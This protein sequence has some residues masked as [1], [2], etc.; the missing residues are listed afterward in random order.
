VR[1]APAPPAPAA[2]APPSNLENVGEAEAP[3]NPREFFDAL[4]QVGQAPPDELQAWLQAHPDLYSIQL[5]TQ[6]VP[7][8]VQALESAD[9]LPT[10]G[11]LEFLL[12]FFGL[13]HIDRRNLFLQP[14]LEKLRDLAFQ[15]HHVRFGPDMSFMLQA[16]GEPRRRPASSGGWPQVVPVLLILVCLSSL[17][18]CVG[19]TSNGSFVIDP[20]AVPRTLP[21]ERPPAS[22]D[23]PWRYVPPVP[24][25]PSSPSQKKP[26]P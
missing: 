20:D 3:F 2:D 12:D 10:P 25:P 26:N 11:G 5:R 15:Q 7:S 6:L 4:L 1:D 14:R 19:N 18:R 21:R 17:A 16:N 13:N 22:D 24:V 23:S 8:L 9:R